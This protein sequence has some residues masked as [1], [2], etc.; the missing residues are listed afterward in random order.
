MGDRLRD[1]RPASRALKEAKNP[2]FSELCPPRYLSDWGCARI[3]GSLAA[4][5][6]WKV[7]GL[8]R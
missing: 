8:N 6:V 7:G 4:T 3:E 5:R 2:L 1:G